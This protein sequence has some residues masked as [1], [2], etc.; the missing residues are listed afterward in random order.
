MQQHSAEAPTGRPRKGEAQRQAGVERVV[1]SDSR[2]YKTWGNRTKL[3]EKFPHLCP[4]KHRLSL[5]TA[6][7]H[8]FLRRTR[9]AELDIAHC[10]RDLGPEAAAVRIVVLRLKA[11]SGSSDGPL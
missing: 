8:S 1:R 9:L 5:M 2:V 4:S 10:C 11:S 6:S 7:R 3:H